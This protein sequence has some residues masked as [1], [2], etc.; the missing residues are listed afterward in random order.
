MFELCVKVNLTH[1]KEWDAS[2]DNIGLISKTGGDE[3]D[4]TDLIYWR[5]N[6]PRMMSKRDY[7]YARR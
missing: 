5:I 7:V 6:F 1:R 4:E 2:T 3:C